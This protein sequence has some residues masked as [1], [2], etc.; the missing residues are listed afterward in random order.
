MSCPANMLGVNVSHLLSTKGA[1][2]NLLKR[3]VAQAQPASASCSLAA[4]L[5]WI[6]AARRRCRL[7]LSGRILAPT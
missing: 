3:T 7:G 6:A 1:R 4:H 2:L 5:V